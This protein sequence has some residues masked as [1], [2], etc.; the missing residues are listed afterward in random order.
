MAALPNVQA[1]ARAGQGTVLKLWEGLGY[2]TRARN[3][4]RAAKIIVADHQGRFPERFEDVLALP[5]IGRYTAG[6]ICS[7]AFGEPRP[8][9]D[10]NVIR[11]LT[12]VFGIAGDPK[13]REVN[14]RLW[15]L[16][17]QLVTRARE[18]PG[19]L[20]QALMELGAI[21]CTAKNPQ[22][23][24]CPVANH[25]SAFKTNRIDKFPQIPK[26]APATAR[27]FHA[28]I[29]NEG[30][31]F[32]V[33]QRPAG[34]ANAHLWEFPNQEI[35]TFVRNGN[36]TQEPFLTIKHSITRYRIT[37]KAFKLTNR[38]KRYEKEGRWLPLTKLHTLPF[39]SAHKQILLQLSASRRKVARRVAD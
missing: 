22:C 5:G 7:I 6:A 39:T 13:A 38:A 27:T 16:A 33:R 10:G 34:V 26:R 19:T 17:G 20:N 3:M 14:E 12:R 2:Y 21:V 23:E 25:C 1:L 37:L 29:I 8:I 36:G 32:F 15:A 4:Q 9:L 35:K 18:N 28:F 11:V 24:L 31:R 30:G